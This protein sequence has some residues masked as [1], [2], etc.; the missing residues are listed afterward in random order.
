MQG[1]QELA[2]SV[3]FGALLALRDFR[4]PKRSAAFPLYRPPEVYIS[5]HPLYFLKMNAPVSAPR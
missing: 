3:P 4:S 1:F 5:V 2:P